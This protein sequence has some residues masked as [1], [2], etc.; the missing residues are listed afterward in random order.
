MKQLWTPPSDHSR[1]MTLD[2]S[3]GRTPCS[4]A[5]ADRANS[6]RASSW[7]KDR[8]GLDRRADEGAS[9]RHRSTKTSVEPVGMVLFAFLTVANPSDGTRSGLHLSL[10]HFQTLFSHVL[11]VLSSDVLIFPSRVS[12]EPRHV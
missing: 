10:V 6:W 1:W 5:A 7:Q 2:R 9:E 8:L 11:S 4:S 3:S 12:S